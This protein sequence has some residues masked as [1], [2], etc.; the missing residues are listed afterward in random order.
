MQRLPP[1]PVDRPAL[2]RRHQPGAGTCRHAI[3]RPLLERGD[4]RVLRQLLG[5]ADVAHDPGEPGDQPGRLDPPDRID[6]SVHR[7]FC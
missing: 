7:C 4:Q 3:R 5:E 1:K 2:R 6:A